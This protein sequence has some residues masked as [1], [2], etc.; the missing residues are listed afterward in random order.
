MSKYIVVTTINHPTQAIEGMAQLEG[1]KLIVVGDRKTPKD[2]HCPNAT[3]LSLE[4]QADLGFTV[5]RY[6]PVGHYARKNIG[7][8]YAM[9][10]G[11]ELIWE[12]DDDTQLLKHTLPIHAADLE[13]SVASVKSRF[14]NMYSLFTQFKVWPRGFPLD[15]VNALEPIELTKKHVFAP[16]QQSLVNNDPD[17]DA[18]YRLVIGRLFDFDGKGCYG[19]ADGQYCPFNSQATLWHRRAFWLMMLPGY[20][21][22]RVTDIWR[23]YI[24]EALLHLYNWTVL[25]R[26]PAVVQHRNEHNLMSDFAEE[27]PLYQDTHRLIEVLDSVSPARNKIETLRKCY[28][29]I[30]ENG[31]FTKQEVDLADAWCEDLVR[32][33]LPV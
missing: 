1:W 14:V 18:I 5:N 13:V 32:Y 25:F 30:Y 11:A 2:W 6:L 9:Q 26:E 3:F 29:S 4:E 17:V 19:L 23:G 31:L 12:T 10:Q 16:V 33:A 21:P 20:V 24:A 15:L 7:Y 28:A 27:L 22:M 8:L